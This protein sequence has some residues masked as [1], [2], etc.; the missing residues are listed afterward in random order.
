MAYMFKAYDEDEAAATVAS[1]PAAAG[2]TRE[3]TQLRR[4]AQGVLVG[5]LLMVVAAPWTAPVAALGMIASGA[6]ILATKPTAD[7]QEQI[8]TEIK[9][10]RFGCA[11]LWWLVMA[12]ILI[13]AGW[14]GIA[15]GLLVFGEM[16]GRL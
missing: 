4:Q 6:L 11:W 15:G 9:A 12:A 10:R 14:V 13:G 8:D 16:A 3:S 2:V 1:A 7:C 5:C